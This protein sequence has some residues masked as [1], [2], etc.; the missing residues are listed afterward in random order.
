MT[1][2]LYKEYL[3]TDSVNNFV[4]ATLAPVIKCFKECCN[5][6]EKI[7]I[8]EYSLSCAFLISVSS[9]YHIILNNDELLIYFIKLNFK[10]DF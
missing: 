5:D 8:E 2:E 6:D 7:F 1:L 10:A 4:M 9:T 3:L